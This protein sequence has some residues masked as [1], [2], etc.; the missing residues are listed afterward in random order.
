VTFILALLAAMAFGASVALQERAATCVPHVH[1]LKVGLLMRLVQRPIW[2]LGLVASGLGFLLQ[3]LALRHGSLVV[4]Q[5]VMTTTLIFALATV[6]FWARE[7]L[8]HAEWLAVGA[9]VAGLIGFLVFAAPDVDSVARASGKAW[10]TSAAIA[11]VAVGLPALSALRTAGGHRAARLGLAAGISNG[12]VAVLTKAFAQDLH[13][14]VSIVRDWPMWGLVAAGIPAVLLVQSVYQSGRLNVSLPIVVVVEPAV[15]SL[16]GIVLFGEAITLDGT[17][18]IGVVGSVVVT[19]VGLWWLAGH[20]RLA[21][22]AT[23][24]RRVEHAAQSAGT[25]TRSHAIPEEEVR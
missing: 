14:G 22:M 19:A 25:V 20:P 15:A 4:V 18:T 13:E 2:L 9:I 12:F 6:A 1:A 5:L 24:P 3:A 17:K 16:A 8:R 7:P 21:A 23:A 10:W 11:V